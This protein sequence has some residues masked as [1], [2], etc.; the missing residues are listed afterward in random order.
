MKTKE[1]LADSFRKLVLTVP[2]RKISIKMITDQA[3][4]IRPTFYNYFQDKY[5]VIEY[6]F[7]K[8][9]KNNVQIMLDNGM[10]QEAIKL[11]FICFEKNMEYYRKLFDMEGQNSFEEYFGKYIHKTYLAILKKHPLKNFSSPLI[12]PDVVAHFNA[13][14]LIEMLKMWLHHTP[15]ISAEEMYKTYRLAI[16]TSVLDMIDYPLRTI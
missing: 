4:V 5:E 6:L 2:F 7:E 16:R 8:D 10:E 13:L 9:I 12:T 15:A 11:M 14:I 1:L 3:G